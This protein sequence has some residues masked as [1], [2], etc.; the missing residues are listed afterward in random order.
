MSIFQFCLLRFFNSSFYK[1]KQD[2]EVKKY[3]NSK[4]SQEQAVLL[5]K[6]NELTKEIDSKKQ[7]LKKIQTQMIGLL[8]REQ[9]I[10]ESF[11]RLKDIE[12]KVGL[13]FNL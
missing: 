10:K 9:K 1:L 4:L 6:N 13:K 7:E 11:Q 5:A 3:K 8:G 12:K 2:N